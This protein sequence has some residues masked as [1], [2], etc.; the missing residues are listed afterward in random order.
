MLAAVPA[1]VVS[2]NSPAAGGL[3]HLQQLQQSL[4]LSKYKSGSGTIQTQIP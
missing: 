1:T 4:T 2:I 3:Y